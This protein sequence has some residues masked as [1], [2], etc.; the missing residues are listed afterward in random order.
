MGVLRAG[1]ETGPSS[2]EAVGPGSTRS[3][4]PASRRRWVEGAVFAL[5]AAALF[6][7]YLRL[8]RT[9]PEN[10]DEANVLLQASDILHGNVLLHGWYKA[11]VSFYTTELPQ[12]VLLELIFGMVANTA[13]IAAAMT[14][15]LAVLL[16]VLVA[17]GGFTSRAAVVRMAIVAG[18]MLAPQ[19]GIGV[20]ALILTVGHIGT[21]VPV[22]LVL[23]L[24]DRAPARWYVA[25]LTALGL[26]WALIADELVL[27]I[28]VVPL[29]LVCALR[30]L[31]AA[32]RE[33]SLPR[34][35]AARKYELSLIAAA[36][37]ATGLAWVA[38]R[39][40]RALGG[41]IL[42]PVPFG[43]SLHDLPANLHSLW[44]VPQIFGADYRG[45]AGGPYY[46]ALLHTISLPL[47]GLALV[48]L[49]WRFFNGAA[50]VDQVLG[51]AIAGNIVLFVVTS[52][53]SEGPHEIAVVAPFGAALAARML[54]GP[55]AASAPAPGLLAR[56]TRTV[57]Y[58]AGIVVLAGYLGGLVHEVVRP[59]S[60]PAFAR[61]ASWLQA[62]HLRYGLGG[63]W[64]S[65]IVTVQTGQQVKV[66]ALLKATL[67]PDLWLA[68]SEWYDPAAQQANFVVL[69]STPGFMNN[70][71]P[72]ALVSKYFGRPAHVYNFGPYTVMV[73]DRNI[74][75]DIP[76]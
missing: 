63:Y 45:L 21:A 46:T 13:H 6:A 28:A 12:Y 31:E 1:T 30:V 38:A 39:V 68:K 41:Y 25:V 44:A 7:V 19:L 52:A 32:I 9:V 74:L 14:Y 17:R 56:R 72:R 10:S 8:S 15:T 54:A 75:S 4:W 53:G 62:H 29:A 64:E 22:L 69:S 71:E 24:L 50:L 23:L 57:A 3:P 34:G 76:R 35:F 70:W 67:A 48:V 2:E 65:S 5:A 47:V 40:L 42:T 51:V 27:V 36:A 73:W 16:A 11:D 60:P 55:R 18:I 26:A 33:R 58:A 20:F 49:A 43:F 66:R 37:V 61:V 59:A